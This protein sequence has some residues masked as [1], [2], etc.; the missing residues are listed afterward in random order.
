MERRMRA[1]AGTRKK[2]NQKGGLIAFRAYVTVILVGGCLLI[3]LFQTETSDMVCVKVKET[4]AYQISAEE[5]A[6]WK[7]KAA[8]YFAGKDIR[9]PVFEKEEPQEKQKT[10]RP[11]TEP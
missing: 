1:R 4:I 10:Y 3:S 9:F 11:D 6:E 7:E 5:F 8:A 2:E